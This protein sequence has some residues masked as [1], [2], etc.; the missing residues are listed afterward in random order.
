LQVFPGFCREASVSEYQYVGFRAIDEPVNK[1]HLD[2]MERQSSHAKSTPWTFDVEYHGGDFRGNAREMLRRGYDVHLHYANF[3]IRTLMIRL[4][5]GLPY[6][7]AAKPYFVKKS[8]EVAQDKKDPGK[9]DPGGTLIIELGFES[10]QLEELWG[11]D[12]FLERLLPLRAE[13]LKGDLRP[14]YLANLAV[15][16]DINH[17]PE[18]WQEPPVPAGL[19]QLTAAQTV[20][21]EFYGLGEALVAAAAGN[22]PPTPAT[23]EI[24]TQNSGDES[25]PR[26]AAQVVD[27]VQSRRA[28]RSLSVDSPMES[29]SLPDYDLRN[30]DKLPRVPGGV[31]NGRTTG[32]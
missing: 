9:K 19:D 3:G 15:A 11:L 1:K 12:G 21:A 32:P 25:R 18:E 23:S 17:D 14:L 8:L 24:P 4:P 6:A 28:L 31:R 30:A 13:V 7:A 16:G 20:L 5:G 27:G 2:F 26:A 29:S 22:T 10:D